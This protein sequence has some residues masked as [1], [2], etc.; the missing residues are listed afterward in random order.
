MAGLT[1]FTLALEKR[2]GKDYFLEGRRLVTRQSGVR[3]GGT[4]RRAIKQRLLKLC[5][6]P[7]TQNKQR[8]R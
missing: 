3:Q 7:Y 5:H 1:G 8:D 2:E 4:L 6:T